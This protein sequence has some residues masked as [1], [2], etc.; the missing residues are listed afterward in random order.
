MTVG[1]RCYGVVAGVGI[2]GN[3][4]PGLIVTDGDGDGVLPTPPEGVAEGVDEGVADGFADGEGV[5]AGVV[6]GL[7]DGVGLGFGVEAAGGLCSRPDD[8]GLP[9]SADTGLPVEASIAVMIPIETAKAT[10]ASPATASQRRRSPGSPRRRECQR[11]RSRSE[12]STTPGGKSS[13]ASSGRSSGRASI[14]VSMLWRVDAPAAALVQSV[15]RAADANCRSRWLV[16]RI[17]ATYKVEPTDATMLAIAAPMR[18]PATPKVD[19]MTAADTAAR[20]L[21]VTWMRLGRAGGLTGPAGWGGADCVETMIWCERS[22]WWARWAVRRHCGL[23]APRIE[24]MPLYARPTATL[25][26]VS[27][28]R[29]TPHVRNHA[30]GLGA[31][32]NR[33]PIKGRP[34]AGP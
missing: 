21:A 20:A 9:T 26:S 19:E 3:G 32:Q 25:G 11:R 16:R 17:D 23:A 22:S 8:F 2:V 10:T 24:N 5:A 14:W 4:R 27:H 31:R 7:A 33:A 1:L 6:V 28:A 29:L 30:A 18:V 13:G 12:G 15:R 34:N